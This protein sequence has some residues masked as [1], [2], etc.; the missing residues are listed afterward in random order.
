MASPVFWRKA[1]TV[2]VT[3]FF[4]RVASVDG[5]S[6]LGHADDVEIHLDIVREDRESGV[7]NEDQ[8]SGFI[9]YT[10]RNQV[11]GVRAEFAGPGQ[12]VRQRQRSYLFVSPFGDGYR[13]WLQKA[14]LAGSHFRAAL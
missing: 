13:R 6:V 4:L 7:G 2:S 14:C 3:R 1:G 10:R 9:V 8:C 11:V 5:G 12:L